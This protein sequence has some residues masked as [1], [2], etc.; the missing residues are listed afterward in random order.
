MRSQSFDF[1]LQIF[2]LSLLLLAFFLQTIVI[3]CQYIIILFFEHKSLLLIQIF[4][5]C[6]FNLFFQTYYFCFLTLEIFLKNCNFFIEDI[7]FFF[8]LLYFSLQIGNFMV[9]LII[10]LLKVNILRWKYTNW[11]AGLVIDILQWNGHLFE[12]KLFLRPILTLLYKLSFQ[13]IFK[14]LLIL[15]RKLRWIVRV[16]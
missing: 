6:F 7:C 5:S 15:I 2:K 9:F 12:L 11:L 14:C 1:L 16:L 4:F 3:F 13:K 8:N 10:I